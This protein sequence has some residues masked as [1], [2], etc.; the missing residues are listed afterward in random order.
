VSFI[1]EKSASPTPPALTMKA[2]GS[3]ETVEPFFY[4]EDGGIRLLQQ[5]HIYQIISH[6]NP[7]D[8]ARV[9]HC[10]RPGVF[11]RYLLKGHIL[12]AERFAGGVHVLQSKVCT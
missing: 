10:C 8:A 2:R 6:R 5:A 11:K 9:A 7:E 3:T 1:K 4:H 12:T